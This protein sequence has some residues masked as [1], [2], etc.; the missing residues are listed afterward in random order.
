MSTLIV[1]AHPDDEVLGCGGLAAGF[2][3]R[4]DPVRACI[5]SGKVSARR[6]RPSL[7]RLAHDIRRAHGMLGLEDAIIGDFPNIAFNA[8]PQLDLVQFIEE[9]L[10]LARAERV[11]TH[12]PADLNSDH[13]FTSV[14]CQAAVRLSHRGGDVPALR[15][16][17]YMEIPSSTDW[18]FAG[19]ARG[20]EPTAFFPLGDDLLH[21]KMD[22]LQAYHRVIREF[23]HPRSPEILRGLAAY[24][25]GQAGVRYAEAFQVAF[26]LLEAGK[27]TEL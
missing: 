7:K 18:A 25:G 24:R 3:R 11:L 6:G 14:A 20:F 10:I 17:L 13:H 1:V 2:A 19:G 26:Q 8:V 9:A 16:L 12:H 23:P 5:L 21:Q 15:M 27:A 22:A 4:G